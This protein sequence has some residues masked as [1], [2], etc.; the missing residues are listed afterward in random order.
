[1]NA[2]ARSRKELSAFP[3]TRTLPLAAR[4]PTTAS[5]SDV[6]PAPLGPMT[7]TISPA[8]TSNDTRST[9]RR[10]DACTVSASTESAAV[11]SPPHRESSAHRLDHHPE[12]A[13]RGDEHRLRQLLHPHHQPERNDRDHDGRHVHDRLAPEHDDGA[14]DGADC[15]G[16]DSIH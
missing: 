11:T 2:L 15:A 12:H 8:S 1:A 6:L 14:S 7:A 9:T 10:R 3:A 16:G 13:H 4:R 5:S